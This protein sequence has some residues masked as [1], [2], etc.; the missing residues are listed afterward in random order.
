M[1]PYESTLCSRKP[2]QLFNLFWSMKFRMRTCIL[3]FLFCLY[4]SNA[5]AQIITTVA[6]SG[7]SGFSGDGG[8]A[9][10]AAFLG[11]SGVAADKNNN[12][13]IADNDNNRIR[14]VDAITGIITTVAGNG[15][16]A[17]AGD[18][19][20]CHFRIIK[21]TYRCSHRCWRQYIYSGLL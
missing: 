12:L 7:V 21:G 9:T 3:F 13:Y 14:K 19:G 2:K 10:M 4:I 16:Y 15:L 17:F 20:A 1:L 5:Y 11:P 8:P 6:G 18:G